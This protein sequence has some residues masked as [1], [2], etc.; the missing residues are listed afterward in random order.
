LKR[1]IFLLSV[2]SNQK[3]R[4]FSSLDPRN[5][6]KW[7]LS[8]EGRCELKGKKIISITRSSVRRTNESL[9]GNHIVDSIS[10]PYHKVKQIRTKF[11]EQNSTQNLEEGMRKI[12]L[13]EHFFDEE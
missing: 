3:L 7:E 1:L 10:M 6:K 9:G 4:F 12:K 2:S 13:Q 5:K 8:F 11:F